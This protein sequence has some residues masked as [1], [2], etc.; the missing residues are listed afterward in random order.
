MINVCSI[1]RNTLDTNVEN[2]DLQN[3]QGNYISWKV[4]NS[5]RVYDHLS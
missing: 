3:S 5:R 1:F 4:R 2:V